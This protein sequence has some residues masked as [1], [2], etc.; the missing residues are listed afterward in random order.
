MAFVVFVSIAV[1]VL[2]EAPF[3]YLFSGS[4]KICILKVSRIVL[5][6]KSYTLWKC[7]ISAFQS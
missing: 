7:V 1:S 3:C 5:Y 6:F 2:P 4:A